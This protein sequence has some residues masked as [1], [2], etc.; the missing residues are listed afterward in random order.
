MLLELLAGFW[1]QRYLD[2]FPFIH[3]SVFVLEKCSKGDKMVR[4][5]K[6]LNCKNKWQKTVFNRLTPVREYSCV[7][8]KLEFYFNAALGPLVQ[9]KWL[10]VVCFECV[11]VCLCVYVRLL[12]PCYLHW[13]RQLLSL[14][15]STELHIDVRVRTGLT[16]TQ[17]LEIIPSVSLPLE[18]ALTHTHTQHA[19]TSENT[20]T[21]TVA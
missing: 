6:F 13:C 12:S 17:T 10:Y 2:S 15:Q 18:S 9:R 20:R 11:C 1:L 16:H 7:W 8:K 4:A 3:P 14:C 19:H 21:Y 5:S